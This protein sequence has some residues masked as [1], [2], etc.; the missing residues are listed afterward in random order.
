[1]K[2]LKFIHITKTGGT[3]IEDIGDTINIKWGRNHKEYGYWHYY[4]PKKPY[5]IK[6]KYDWFVV[7]RNPYERI[8]SEY[9]CKWG[10]IGDMIKFINLNVSLDNNNTIKLCEK[11]SEIHKLSF[12]IEDINAVLTKEFMNKFLF[13]KIK[14]RNRLGDHYA[15]QYKYLDNNKDIIIHVLKFENLKNDFDNLMNIYNINLTLDIVNN[16][17]P[18]KI[19]TINDF[20]DELIKLIND[21]Y[22]KDF[23]MFNYEKINII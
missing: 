19:F 13:E 12:T 20:S 21:I 15:E 5:T 4:F 16:K 6:I 14:K 3:S 8:L 2:E 22:H 11:F 7:V 18:N 9:F 10:G 17:S 23:E 1:M